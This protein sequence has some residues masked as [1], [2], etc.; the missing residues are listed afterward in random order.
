MLLNAGADNDI[1]YTKTY[2]SLQP[3]DA[4]GEKY[5]IGL[6]ASVVGWQFKRDQFAPVDRGGPWGPPRRPCGGLSM[7][8]SLRGVSYCSISSLSVWL[9]SSEIPQP[10]GALSQGR[11]G[12]I[13]APSG[14]SIEKI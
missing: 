13:D 4:P 5:G 7:R 9:A 1:V 3:E 6:S 12:V 11:P 10:G 2:N 8:R 14:L